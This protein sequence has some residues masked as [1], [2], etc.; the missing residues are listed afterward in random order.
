MLQRITVMK[1]FGTYS[2]YKPSKNFPEWDGTFKKNNII[3]AHN[4][5]GKTTFSLIFQ[6]LSSG[7][8]EVLVKKKRV[9]S[10]GEVEIRLLGSNANYNF[11]N[12]KWDTINNSINVFNSFYFQDNV[13]AFKFSDDEFSYLFKA[14]EEI[15]D[16]NQKL[17]KSLKELSRIKKSIKNNTFF[18]KEKLKTAKNSKQKEK[19]LKSNK[20]FLLKKNLQHKKLEEEITNSTPIVK[21]FYQNICTQYRDKVNYYLKQFTDSILI[22]DIKPLYSK[23]VRLQSIVFNLSVDGFETS[24][25]KRDISFDFYLSDGDKNS[26]AFASFLARLDMMEMDQLSKQILVFDDPFSSLDSNRKNRTISLISRYANKVNQIFVF[27]HDLYFADELSNRFYPKSDLLCL[28]MSKY[29]GEARFN[30]KENFRLDTKTLLIQRIEKLHKYLKNGAPINELISIKNDIRPV[31]EGMFK[32]KFYK[33][34]LDIQES[35]GIN[36]DQLWLKNYIDFV[37]QSETEEK[38]EDFKRLLPQL[39]TLRDVQHYCSKPHHD[40]SDTSYS[41]VV[42]PID[43]KVYVKDTLDLLQF[44]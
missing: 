11:L 44:I 42:D 38:Y 29:D 31:L 24:L 1:N 26:I 9:A 20:E 32:I 3:Y 14:N 33:T 25:G 23:S 43:L 15:N 12:Q 39:P 17:T 40:Q 35:G 34:L 37:E 2:T 19:I 22:K 16:L 30:V 27:S 6:S 21:G 18:L 28:E 7:S 4:G 41:Q 5:S 36:I 10:D 8:G 13:Y